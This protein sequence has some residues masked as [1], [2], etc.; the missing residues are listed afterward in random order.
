M[1]DRPDFP[2]ME[3]VQKASVEDLAR[4]YR[5]LPVGDTRE[6]QEIMD[7]ITERL[8]KKGGINENGDI[9]AAVSKRIGHGGV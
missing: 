4:W 9:A 6:H 3:E 8:K 7:S 1:S 2:T 5:F